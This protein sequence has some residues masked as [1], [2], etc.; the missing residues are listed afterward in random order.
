[1]DIEIIQQAKILWDYL[2][3]DQ[4]LRKADC[5]IAMGSHDLRTGEY[6]AQLIIDGWAPLLVCSGG[7]GRLTRGIWK[8]P[9]AYKFA[10]SAL[11]AG[12]AEEHILIEGH[13]A[14]TAE[15]LRFSR[16]LLE[17]K[18]FFIHSAILVHKPYMERRTLATAGIAWPELNCIITSPPI[19][20]K[21]YPT[22]EIPLELVIDIMVGDFQRIIVYA[23]KGY[24]TQQEVPQSVMSA[25]E[26]LIARGFDQYL[27]H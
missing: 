21:E 11:G 14:N 25:F 10:Q 5:V 8:E 16:E 6:A 15:N 23:E 22:D 20:F 13:S 4:P 19:T 9:E 3:L 1:M 7:L 27:I 18:G 17:E 12:V 2:K 26:N 24:Q